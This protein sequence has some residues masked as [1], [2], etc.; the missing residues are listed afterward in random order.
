MKKRGEEACAAGKKVENFFIKG[1]KMSTLDS[2]VRSI[3]LVREQLVG[4]DFYEE[5]K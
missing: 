5:E 1:L 2:S 4:Q 3:V